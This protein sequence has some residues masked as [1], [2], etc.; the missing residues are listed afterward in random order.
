MEKTRVLLIEDDA[1]D[2]LIF[3]RLVSDRRLPYE[4]V[5]ADSL[6]EAKKLLQAEAFDIVIAD[7]MLGDGTA[8]D[9]LKLELDTPVIIITGGGSEQVAVVAMKAGAYD[10][11]IKDFEQHYLEILPM[12]VEKALRHK[13][14]EEELQAYKEHLEELVEKR[15]GELSSTVE[16]LHAEVMTHQQTAQALHSSEQKFRELSQEFTVLLDAIPDNLL[17]MSPDLK[18]MWANRVAFDSL[19]KDEVDI[20]GQYCH[21]LWHGQEMP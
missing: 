11:L 13:K 10:Y 14:T 16:D 17:L 2:Q 3:K 18:V 4:Y 5:V 7:Y 1:S 20:T 9:I 19:V 12:T 21:T 6:S 8:L 15:T